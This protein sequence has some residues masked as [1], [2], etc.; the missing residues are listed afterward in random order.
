M[1]ILITN[2]LQTLKESSS[3]FN[4]I[5]FNKQNKNHENNMLLDNI[6]ATNTTRIN[7]NT[8]V[9]TNT[10]FNDTEIYKPNFN[11][12]TIVLRVNSEKY[13]LA[14][15]LQ[16]IFK[17]LKTLNKH[18]TIT[19]KDWNNMITHHYNGATPS[20]FQPLFTEYNSTITDQRNTENIVVTKIIKV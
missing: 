14:G 12:Y 18:A 17:T 3:S 15:T 5:V 7:N 4:M 9:V 19:V 16:D 6:R 1:S 20:Q 11:N 10:Y 8:M 2:D 13:D